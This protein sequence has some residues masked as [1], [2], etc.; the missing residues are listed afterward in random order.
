MRNAYILATL[1]FWLVVG[2]IWAGSMRS[3]AT[4]H[5]SAPAPERA[6]A[7]TELARHAGADD[8]WIAIRGSVYD[9]T[10]YLPKHPSR[11]GTIEPWCG[12]EATEAY[13]TKTRGRPHS[14]EADRLLTGYRIGTFAAA[15]SR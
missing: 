7:A 15:T 9:V 1:S 12:K 4:D 10:A 14:A 6:V 11:P 13:E 3:P 5:V 2:L 8:C